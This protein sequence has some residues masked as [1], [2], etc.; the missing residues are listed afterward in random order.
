M[1]NF[2]GELRARPGQPDTDTGLFFSS[3]PH[4]ENQQRA[5]AA[6]NLPSGCRHSASLWWLQQHCQPNTAICSHFSLRVPVCF[7]TANIR[8]DAMTPTS[9]DAH[10]RIKVPTARPKAGNQ[11]Q[12]RDANQERRSRK[13][14]FSNV[15]WDSFLLS[16]TLAKPGQ[17]GMMKKGGQGSV[18]RPRHSASF[19]LPIRCVANL[20][21]TF[22]NMHV[23]M[24]WFD[25]S[26]RGNVKCDSVIGR[27]N[28]ATRKCKLANRHSLLKFLKLSLYLFHFHRECGR[29]KP[30]CSC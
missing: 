7:V 16:G 12:G 2:H 18:A 17:P 15:W 29:G 13:V 14:A 19:F 23:S 11:C 8:V 26:M 24:Q 30:C 28:V 1:R 6:N 9:N 25:A 3:S 21:R 10:R 4:N 27:R 22:E 20:K 5:A